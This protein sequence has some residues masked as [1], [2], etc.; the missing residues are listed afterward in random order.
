MDG[1]DATRFTVDRSSDSLWRV[2]F[3]NPP[4]N[5]IDPQMVVELHQLLDRIQKD[6]RLVVVVFDSADADFFLAHYDIAADVRERLLSAAHGA[7]RHRATRI[8]ATTNF[9]RWVPEFETASTRWAAREWETSSGRA[10][11]LG[12]RRL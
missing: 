11:G 9:V 6:K 2:T 12:H 8:Q 10:Y 1:T 5:L 4:I 3:D 7:P